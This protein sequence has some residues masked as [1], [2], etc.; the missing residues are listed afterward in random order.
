MTITGFMKT[1]EFE[2]VLNRY[3]EGVLE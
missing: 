1:E 2:I 3:S